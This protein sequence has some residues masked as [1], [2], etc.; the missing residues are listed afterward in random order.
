M[1]DFE[2]FEKS[3]GGIPKDLGVREWVRGIWDSWFDEAFPPSRASTE[4]KDA[5]V[6]TDTKK[7]DSAEQGKPDL[8]IELMD[9]VNPAL[10]EDIAEIEDLETE[11]NRLTVLIEKEENS[12]AFHYC[13][14]G[15]I[16]RKLGKLKS[17]MDDL[18][19]VSLIQSLFT[20]KK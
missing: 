11:I 18:E 9:S 10:V 16:N 13:R 1:L 7:V 15:A 5:K 19:K 17:A 4:E 14:R 12:S 6:L 3:K 2:K 8:E 20:T